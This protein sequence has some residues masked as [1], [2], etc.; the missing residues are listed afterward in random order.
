MPS[1]PVESR[2]KRRT[3]TSASRRRRTKSALTAKN[4]FFMHVNDAWLQRH[5][6]PR[7]FAS[8]GY[9]HLLY[10]RIDRQLHDFCRGTGDRSPSAMR[11]H[12]LYT[13]YMTVFD[14]PDTVTRHIAQRV[15]RVRELAGRA[16]S[17]TNE[18]AQV[19]Q[20]LGVIATLDRMGCDAPLSWSV[21][22]DSRHSDMRV[23]HLRESG[24]SLGE[25]SH[26]IDRAHAGV[27]KQYVA[28]INTVAQKWRRCTG[29]MLDCTNVGEAV[30]YVETRLAERMYAP[31]EQRDPLKLY[32]AFDPRTPAFGHLVGGDTSR[33]SDYWTAMGLSARGPRKVI[34]DHVSYVRDLVRHVLCDTKCRACLPVYWWWKVME[35]SASFLRTLEPAL[36][37]FF[38]R[39]LLGTKTRKPRWKRA[40]HLVNAEL[41]VTL[42][43]RYV[44]HHVEH[45]LRA[46]VTQL[47]EMLRASFLRRLQNVKWMSPRTRERAIRKLRR[48]RFKIAHPGDATGWR[49]EP[50][51]TL[52]A[53]DLCGNLSRLTEWG[54]QDELRREGQPVV[55]EIWEDAPQT[56][57]A[58]YYPS[59]N[60]IV[61]PA[62]ILQPPYF[63]TSNTVAQNLGGI[64]ATIGHE[65]THGFDDEGRHY[66]EVGCLENWWTPADAKGFEQHKRSIVQ[67]YGQLTAADRHVN[68]E[69]TCG[70]NIADMGGIM[71]AQDSLLRYCAEKGLE[72]AATDD[73]LRDFYR[74][75]A[76][77][78]CEHTR[79]QAMRERL[80]SDPHSPE[81]H[82]VNAVLGRIPEFQRVFGI[83]KK[84]AMYHPEPID[85]W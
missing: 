63:A 76:R 33:W 52:D 4:D 58:Y 8:W 68:G 85:I 77:S 41:D 1:T 48:M 3:T 5:A 17:A 20:T 75:Y 47:A 66:N 14:H 16:A 38:E 2:R 81:R 22:V 37:S 40:V 6:I 64:G 72:A 53:N 11:L 10:Q 62:A 32:N 24:I 80:L 43:R 25:K 44:Q 31:E 54:H 56:V 29:A 23:S 21:E 82:R 26:Y 70:E 74:S 73:M 50:R 42:A 60:E 84:D 59:R 67:Q 55:A 78:W 27:R 7:A 51:L 46:E 30:L 19:R 39:T 79:P 61:M 71:I 9:G 49:R 83:T 15:H 45:T 36:F 18:D 57:N 69:L 12:H 65:M 13:S 35:A 34:I 28:M